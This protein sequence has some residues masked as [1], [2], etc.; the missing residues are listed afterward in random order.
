[1]R[2]IVVIFKNRVE[3]FGNLR[4]FIEEYPQYKELVNKM[5][6]N[7]F[8]KKRVFEHPDFRLS[9]LTVKQSKNKVAK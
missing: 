9:R 1:M 4:R 8:R 2:I 5:Y 3:A 6:Y 7:I